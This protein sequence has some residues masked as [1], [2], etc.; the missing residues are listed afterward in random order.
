MVSRA[1]VHKGDQ[2]LASH[3]SR[4]TD[5]APLLGAAPDSPAD[6]GDPR[7]PLAPEPGMQ[8]GARLR[9]LLWIFALLSA[10]LVAPYIAGRIQYELTSA[11]ERAR[12]AIAREHLKD[13]NL[14]QLNTA[15][16]LL[17]QAIEPSVVSIR[18]HR[19]IG[20]GLGSGVIVDA[21]GYIITNHHV[22]AE[23]R[24][25]E[26]ELSD[27][28]TGSASVVGVDPFFD[29]AVLKTELKNLAPAA[30]GDSDRLRAGELVWAFGSPFGLQKTITRGIVS[31]TERRSLSPNLDEEAV[32]LQTDAAVN[33][34]NSGGPLVNT[35][36]EV[37]GINTAIVGEEYLGVSF[38]IPSNRA[39]ATYD[40]IRQGGDV[41][42]GYLGVAPIYLSVRQARRMGLPNNQ[43]VLI[44]SVGRD[45][46]AEDAGIELGDVILSWNGSSFDDPTALSRAIAATA[47]GSTAEVE[48]IRVVPDGS[49]EHLTVEVTVAAR[50][51]IS[52]PN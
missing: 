49:V 23:F 5:E 50:P 16:R 28:R 13:F 27:G 40:A 11:E 19:G 24:S 2:D 38:A 46:P 39:R 37:V 47:I 4:L 15:H 21:A 35:D 33:P 7:P 36:G 1:L 29:L 44:A 48:L 34:G 25:A 9:R 41:E 31:A 17:A 51:R 12:L 30:W 43:G 8:D 3:D 22:V 6:A 20:E 52:A 45:T 14:T 18:T 42:R 26:I 10:V 32:F